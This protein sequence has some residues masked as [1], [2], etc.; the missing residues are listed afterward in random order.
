MSGAESFLPAGM[1]GVGGYGKVFT[2]YRESDGSEFAA[3]SFSADEG[4][5]TLE[6]GT[7]RELSILLALRR[8]R[9][10]AGLRPHENIM[11]PVAVTEIT[12]V[13]GFCMIMP[14]YSMSLGTAIK[15]KA[16]NRETKLSV[17]LDLMKALDF[18][19][20]NHCIHRDLKPDNIM[21]TDGFKAVLADFS[22]TKVLTSA[23]PE[24]GRRVHKKKGEAAAALNTAGMGTPTYMAPEV[25]SSGNYTVA[26]DIWSAGVVIY[27]TIQG[28]VLQASKDKAA[29][30][31]LDDVRA[32]LSADKPVPALLRKLIAVDSAERISAKDAVIALEA[33]LQSVRAKGASSTAVVLPPTAVEAVAESLQLD[34]FS[35]W[36]SR[37]LPDDGEAVSSCAVETA[38]KR[39]KLDKAAA[40]KGDKNDLES[41]IEQCCKLLNTQHPLTPS[42]A[43][44]VARRTGTQPIYA[45][46][47]CSKLLEVVLTNLEELEDEEM[48]DGS[49]VGF[50]LEEY[51]QVELDIMKEMDHCM[52][53]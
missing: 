50:F 38:P 27:E 52:Y 36:A 3:K 26:A 31:I 10:R 19:H 44:A 2:V 25:V 4:N 49:E 35:K 8:Q 23:E 34:Y 11:M 39:R 13:D 41:S 28:E 29:F 45:V 1:L 40:K 7:V 37:A 24:K 46:V 43:L 16:L 9:E 33:A 15:A 30:R 47:L 51:V 21:I 53:P 42:L 6:P 22:L 18:L 20:A 32:R 14:K 17:S 12:G 48:P 5:G